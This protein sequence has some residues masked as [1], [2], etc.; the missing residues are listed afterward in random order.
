MI[1]APPQ[2][3]QCPHCI[4]MFS[5]SNFASHT[6]RCKVRRSH[7]ISATNDEMRKLKQENAEL[8]RQKNEWE[9]RYREVVDINDKLIAKLPRQSEV[10]KLD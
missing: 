8:Y 4:G 3:K 2:Q 6:K 9:M 7:E 1:Q 10:V 5:Y